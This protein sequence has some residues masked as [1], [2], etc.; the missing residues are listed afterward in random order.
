[1]IHVLH[2]DNELSI[3]E[4]VRDLRA[5]AG[6]PEVSE[7]NTSVFRGATVVPAQLMAA[8]CVAPFLAERRVVIVEG[9]LTRLEHPPRER[10]AD[11]QVWDGL[12]AALREVP[13]TTDVVFVDA[14]V[15]GKG[16]RRNGPGVRAVGPEA[17]VR[18]F[19]VPRRERLQ[20]WIRDR[21]AALGAQVRPDAVARLAWL[22]GGNLRVL[23][24]EIRK[25]AA[26]A[27]DRPITR[28]DVD[29][30]ASSAREENVFAAVDAVLERRPGVAA[31]ALYSL[32]EAGAGVSSIINL[33]ARQVRLVLLARSLLE[34]GVKDG[35]EI[36]T[37]IGVTH[38][39]VLDKTLRQARRFN[40]RY[41]E[42]IHRRLLE[43][44]LASKT[45]RM[46]DRLS[47]E[48]LVARLSGVS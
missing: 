13:A 3:E 21:A 4:A 1:L 47:L 33:L 28:E 44:D 11:L 31:R 20:A 10:S 48:I 2:G 41:L 26:Y 43:A 27:G 5:A 22:M 38:G 24:Q 46:D 36:G 19:S 6:P 37:R 12:G 29:L 7:A 16:L 32:A 17:R 18:E 42:D 25:L 14:S 30:L 39:F 23:D 8:A 9:L 35:R 15:G 34:A 40:A 45:G